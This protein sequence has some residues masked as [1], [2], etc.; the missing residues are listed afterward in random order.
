MG[1][2]D[3]DNIIQLKSPEE[4][5]PDLLMELL[6]KG[7]KEF[8]GQAVGA[9]LEELLAQYSEHK[10]NGKQAMVRTSIFLAF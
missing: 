8:I 6:R 7:A 10:I 4:N 5:D 9:E 3:D 1:K 2:S